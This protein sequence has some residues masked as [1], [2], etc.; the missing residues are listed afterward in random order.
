VT[1][2]LMSLMLSSTDPDRLHSWYTAV[3]P[4]DTDDKQDQYQILGYG[5]FY[6]FLDSRD[7][8]GERT[9]EPGRVVLNFDVADARGFAHRVEH[10]GGKWEAPLEDREGSLFATAIDPD[11]NL[12]QVIQLSEEHKAQMSAQAGSREA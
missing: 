9:A 1:T 10:V 4:P 12:V 7:D 8:V 6:L 3:L 5:G 2:T 11:G